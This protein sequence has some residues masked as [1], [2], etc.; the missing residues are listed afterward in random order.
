MYGKKY[1]GTMRQTFVLDS[2]GN[3]VH[4]WDKVDTKK[5]A[6]EVLEWVR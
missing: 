1:M 5:H 4:K 6:E 2:S 3:V